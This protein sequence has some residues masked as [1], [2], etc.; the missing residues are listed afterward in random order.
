MTFVDMLYGPHAKV[1]PI[2]RRT[3]RHSPAEVPAAIGLDDG[4][5]PIFSNQ[6]VVSARTSVTNSCN[7]EY[8][9]IPL[10]PNLLQYP[11]LSDATS[12]GGRLAAPG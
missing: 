5:T 4:P 6:A 1:N 8:G 10:N 2:E 7:T 3:V 12:L 9:G 11:T